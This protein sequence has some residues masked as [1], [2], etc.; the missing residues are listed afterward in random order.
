MKFVYLSSSLLALSFVSC[1]QKSQYAT[2]PPVVEKKAATKKSTSTSSKP[3]STRGKAWRTPP[4]PASSNNGT[5]AAAASEVKEKVSA[6]TPDPTKLV[7]VDT[8]PTFVVPENIQ[9]KVSDG[10]NQAEFI[11]LKW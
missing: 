1:Q 6:L 3:K 5:T 7:P 9:P 2:L 8:I 10:I 4:R 11:E